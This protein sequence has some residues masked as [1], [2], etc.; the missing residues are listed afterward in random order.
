MPNEYDIYLYSSYKNKFENK[1]NEIREYFFDGSNLKV[2]FKSSIDNKIYTYSKGNYLLKKPVK[3]YSF[4]KYLYQIAQEKNNFNSDD[5]LLF[6]IYSN[7]INQ[8]LSHDSALYA[9]LNPKKIKKYC[10]KDTLIF[11]FSTNK[12]QCEAVEKAFTS[13]ITVIEGPPGRA[14]EKKSVNSGNLSFL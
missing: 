9:F 14:C 1:T 11:P 3:S 6:N 2:I 7:F 12:S 8:S 13:Q 10:L 4:L 5:T